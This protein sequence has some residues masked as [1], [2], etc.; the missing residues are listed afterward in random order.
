[1]WIHGY[2]SY[3]A[4]DFT[5]SFDKLQV[6]EGITATAY[7]P[8]V[9]DF[10]TVIVTRYGKNLFDKSIPISNYTTLDNSYKYLKYYVGIGTN[11]TVSIAEKPTV[12]NDNGFMYVYPNTTPKAD[13]NAKWLAHQT[14]PE[15][16]NQ[17]QTVVSTDGYVC[18]VV[19]VARALD[20]YGNSIQIELGT[21]ATEYEPYKMPTE[22]TPAADGTVSNVKSLYPITTLMTDTEGAIIEAEYNRD[23]NK[24]FA[25]LQQAILSMGGNT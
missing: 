17:Q 2:L 10:S 25:E 23:I 13:V 16:C 3:A 12:P 18:L 8:Y 20:Y 22:Y 14:S 1:M 6:E 9:S 11:F 21:T 24:A 19:S 15:L 5:F 4:G 7:T